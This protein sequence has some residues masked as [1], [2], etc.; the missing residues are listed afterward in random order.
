MEAGT[1]RR[2]RNVASQNCDENDRSSNQAREQQDQSLSE[3]V[4]HW[5]SVKILHKI[6]ENSRVLKYKIEID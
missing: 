6:A 2:H 1:L 5:G 4:H 3:R